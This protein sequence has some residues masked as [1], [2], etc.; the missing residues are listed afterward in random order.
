VITRAEI[1]L[2]LTLAAA[3]LTALVI[4]VRLIART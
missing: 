4:V 1:A 2:G 3:S